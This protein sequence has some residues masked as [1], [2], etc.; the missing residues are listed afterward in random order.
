MR[1]YYAVIK[2]KLVHVCGGSL[3][4]FDPC[5]DIQT[6]I[7]QFNALQNGFTSYYTSITEAVWEQINNCKGP[8]MKKC[9]GKSAFNGCDG[10]YNEKGHAKLVE[11]ISAQF[12]QIM[13]WAS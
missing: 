2:P 7:K 5:A 4:D 10:H 11:G 1:I 12:E 8:G 13:G 6:A 3:H 9:N